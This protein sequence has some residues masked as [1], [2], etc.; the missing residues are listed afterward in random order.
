MKKILNRIIILVITGIIASSCGGKSTDTDEA[1]VEATAIED[2][3]YKEVM[4]VH[5]EVMPKMG[6][7]MRLKGS[8]H[9]KLDSISLQDANKEQR[10]ILEQAIIELE[11]ADEAMMQWMRNFQPQD[12]VAEKEKVI[13]YYKQ[14]KVEIK[15]VKT[16]M[17]QAINNG[18]KILKSKE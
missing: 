4:D 7:I 8:L 13:N 3:L 2:V 1:A 17:L 16:K 6:D 5:D 12:K 15:G 18:R 11:E 14:Q 10:R 9:E